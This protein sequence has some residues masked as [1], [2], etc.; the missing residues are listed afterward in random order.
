MSVER[1]SAPEKADPVD[2]ARLLR[3][4]CER[5]SKDAPTHNTDE[6]SPVHHWMISSART[7]MDWGIVRPRAL[8]VLRLIASSKFVD[9]STGRSAGLAPFRMRSTYEAPRR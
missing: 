3:L 5:C 7:R 8:A 4:D 6:R 2:L 9:C 1:W